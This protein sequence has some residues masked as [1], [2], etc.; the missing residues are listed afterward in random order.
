MIPVSSCR[1]CSFR[2]Y[3][4][5]RDTELLLTPTVIHTDRDRD[6]ATIQLTSQQLRRLEAEASIVRPDGWPPPE[7]HI[8]DPILFVGYPGA[9]RVQVGDDTVDFRAESRLAFIHAFQDHRFVCMLDPAYRN[10]RQVGVEELPAT[11]M[12]GLSGG[13]AFLVRQEQIL[14]PRLCGII[15]Q[16]SILADAVFAVITPL[17]TVER[18]G[19]LRI[20][21]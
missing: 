1:S 10:S 14:V 6:L 12:P 21:R 4:I 9:L 17:D 8:D 11:D 20:E 13:P 5:G 3:I 2:P 7:L 15:V 19:S 18:D 16:G